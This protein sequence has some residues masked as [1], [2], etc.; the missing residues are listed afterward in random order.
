MNRQMDMY[1]LFKI[2]PP[3]M[4]SCMKTCAR[5]NIYTDTFPM[6]GKRCQYGNHMCGTSGDDI[7]ERID[8]ENRVTFYCKFYKMK[9]E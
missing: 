2:D 3:Q 9:E 6:G 4:W 7:Y 1:E 8:E 5:A